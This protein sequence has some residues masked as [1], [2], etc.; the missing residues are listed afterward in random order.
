K[1]AF[2]VNIRVICYDKR[3]LLSELSSA[4]SSLGINISSANIDTVRGENATCDF[5]L[6]VS[7]LEQFNTLVSALKKLK[8][9]QSVERLRGAL[10][11]GKKKAYM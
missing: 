6:D 7:D 5:E 2:P 1:Q 4:I 10:Q 8:S 9:V 11:G 3:G